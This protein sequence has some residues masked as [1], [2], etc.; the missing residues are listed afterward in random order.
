M[1]SITLACAVLS[2]FGTVAARA[3]MRN[4]VNLLLEPPDRFSWV[5]RRPSR[6]WNLARQYMRF[7]PDGILLF[8]WN[9][10]LALT[11]GFGLEFASSLKNR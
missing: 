1:P 3:A 9:F 2:G 10:L 6:V 4:R 11:C 7:Y 5:N 8:I